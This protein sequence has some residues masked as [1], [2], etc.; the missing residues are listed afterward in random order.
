MFFQCYV[1]FA[2]SIRASHK[3]QMNFGCV[4][5]PGEAWA[6]PGFFRL[7]YILFYQDEIA[8]LKYCKNYKLNYICESIL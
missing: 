4:Q 5:Q 6:P 1:L 8:P 3:V 7:R 2:F